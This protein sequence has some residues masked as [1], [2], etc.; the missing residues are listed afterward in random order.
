VAQLV[1]GVGPNLRQLQQ[2]VEKLKLYTGDRTQIGLDDVEQV[3]SRQR[4]AR[5]FALGEALGD[6]DLAAVMRHLDAELWTLKTDS[7]K[8]EMGLLYGLI[9]KIRAMI[10]VKALL[11]LKLISADADYNRFKGQLEKIPAELLSEDK[12][13]SP[14]SVNP[15]VL[16]KAAGQSRNF[17]EEELAGAMERLLEGNLQLVSSG[18]DGGLV[19]SQMLTQI[20]QRAPGLAPGKK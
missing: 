14:L 19:L 6:R 17:T 15:Y 5:A 18:L 4:H 9:S 16:F 12:K 11:K 8:S 13:Y 20:C 10:F 2:E 1:A 3:S 7:Q